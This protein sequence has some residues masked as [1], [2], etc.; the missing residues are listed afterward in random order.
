MINLVKAELYRLFHR[1][2]LYIFWSILIALAF[3]NSAFATSG[4]DTVLSLAKA[5]VVL[6]VFLW[7]LLTDII[8]AEEYKYNTY[9]NTVTYGVTK[10]QYY[11]T[12]ALIS[13]ILV[14]ITAFLTVL[15][16]CV[17]ASLTYGNLFGDEFFI[18][19]VL[20][21]LAALPLYIASAIFSV[22]L[23][24]LIKKGSQASFAYWGIIM[25]S[26]IIN[27]VQLSGGSKAG[28]LVKSLITTQLINLIGKVRMVEMR[29][30]F[31]SIDTAGGGMVGTADMLTAAMTG[32]AHILVLL[33]VGILLN[34]KWK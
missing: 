25:F 13:S 4:L 3:V 2:F 10:I 12:K 21:I 20:S 6:P 9:I 17:G 33:T 28:F 29:S 27:Y 19:F 7:P 24:L 32:I 31:I 16:L 26:Y 34:R 22:I 5:L 30:L 18:N 15:A 8:T 11:L 23:V 1:K 14:I